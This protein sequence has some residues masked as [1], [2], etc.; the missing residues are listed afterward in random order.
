MRS[1]RSASWCVFVCASLIAAGGVRAQTPPSRPIIASISPVSTGIEGGEEI[2][3]QGYNFT[4]GMT[5]VLG[6]AVVTELTVDDASHLRFRAPRQKAPGVR[7]LTVRTTTGT[8]QERMRIVPKPLSELD[9]CEITTVA[10]GLGDVVDGDES[11]GSQIVVSPRGVAI[12]ASGNVYV[13]DSVNHRVRRL[14]ASRTLVTTVAGCGR[15]GFDGDGG[16]ALTAA[17]DGPSSVAVDAAGNLFVTDTNNRRIRRVDA[18]TGVITTVA[19]TGAEGLSGD[20]G[21]A[22]EATFT[23]PTDVEVDAAGNLFISDAWNYRVRRVDA[24]TGV[25]TS[26]AGGGTY[27]ETGD[28]NGDGGLAVEA[29]VSPMGIDLDASGNLFIADSHTLRI[30]RVDAATGVITSIAGKGRGDVD[31]FEGPATEINL[32]API[33]V[34]V[35]PD[36]TFYLVDGQEG[37]GDIG[38]YA[39][40][41]KVDPSG[42]MSL[43][44]RQGIGFVSS[45]ALDATGNLYLGDPEDGFVRII[46]ASS[47]LLSTLAG[48]GRIEPSGASVGRPAAEATLPDLLDLDVSPDGTFHLLTSRSR[49]VWRV[50]TETGVV[51]EVPTT[52]AE[53]D[54]FAGVSIAVDRAG[55]VIMSRALGDSNWAVVSRTT[56][57][58]GATKLVAGGGDRMPRPGLA[59]RRAYFNLIPTIALRG[60]RLYALDVGSLVVLDAKTGRIRSVRSVDGYGPLAVDSR[61]GLYAAGRTAIARLERR[62]VV[63]AGTG[64]EEVSGDGGPAT[65]AGLGLVTDIAFDAADN[66]YVLAGNRVRRIDAETGIIT[67]IA[68]DGHLGYTG[69]AGPATEATLDEAVAIDVDAE[70]NVYV[71]T[72]SGVVRAIRTGC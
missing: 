72:R 28:P 47:G 23:H 21:P 12:D 41:R 10:G 61:G 34:V 30:R 50:P 60:D 55:N 13:A 15:V 58:N 4:P 39:I 56:V 63:V 14:D 64:S 1:I 24:A 7:T 40:I 19:G 45:L 49:R 37:G 9:P 54:S 22:T 16:L 18:A 2:T 44:D 43:L 35:A 17:L 59:G 36:G 57:R 27:G 66:L 11:G 69:D 51:E 70:G 67:T 68:G 46:S 53:V 3:V 31:P 5:V 65:G 33:D 32:Y 48:S 29:W 71:A 26:V 38:S 8:D 62:T 6:D 20:G 52:S 25:I 42:H